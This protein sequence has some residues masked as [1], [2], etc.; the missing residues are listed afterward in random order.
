MYVGH[1]LNATAASPNDGNTLSFQRI[2]LFIRSRVHEFALVVLDARNIRPLE[3]VQDATRIDK[4]FCFV[5]ENGS[6]SKIA[7]SELPDAFRCVPLS[8][9][10]LVLELDVFVDEIVLFVNAFQISEDL[11]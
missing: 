4:K 10:D 1:D 5:V 8:V 9:F 11:W 7:N 6:R 3:I 2:P